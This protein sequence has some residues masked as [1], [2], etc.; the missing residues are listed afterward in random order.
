MM[1]AGT[2]FKNMGKKFCFA[3]GTISKKSAKNSVK[4]FLCA[5]RAIAYMNEAKIGLIGSRP[6]GFEIS[7][8]DELAIKKVFGTTIIKISMDYFLTPIDSVD[9][10]E[11]DLDMAI[12]KRIFDIEKKDLEDA[13]NLSSIYIAIKK[14]VNEYNL[15]AYAP[16]CWPEL[17][18]DRK[19]PISTANGRMTAEGIM[20]SCEA[21]MDSALTMLLLHALNGDTP[22]TADFV[23]IVEQKDSLLFWHC[24]NASYNLSE[25][26][27]KIEYVSEGLAQTASLR[28]GIVTVCRVNHYKGNFEIFS[29]VGGAIKSRP[30]VKG[31][32]MFVR[33]FKGNM[34]FVK[35][36]LENGIPHH[37]VIIYGDVSEELEIFANLKGGVN[38]IG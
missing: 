7:G 24:G 10:K 9:K 5:A 37:N 31:S 29:G 27:P 23:N 21:D 38:P 3:Y 32:S 2:F 35:S 18:M 6:D 28:E 20:A 34:D 16:Q 25:Q 33:M 12:Q 8:F 26:K 11:I 14:V 17:R 4:K 1:P 30:I 13:K 36:M 15:Q 22:W 19:T